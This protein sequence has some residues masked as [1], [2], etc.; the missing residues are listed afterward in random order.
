MPWPLVGNLWAIA[1]RPP[2]YEP[3]ALWR[4][5][6]GPIYTVWFGEDPLVV[7]ADYQVFWVEKTFF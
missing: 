5:R 4:A 1:R 6:Y 3:F 2:G 7:V